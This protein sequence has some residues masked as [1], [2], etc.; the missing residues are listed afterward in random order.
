MFDRIRQRLALR[1]RRAERLDPVP[2]PVARIAP[3]DSQ[4]LLVLDQLRQAS[5]RE[6]RVAVRDLHRLSGLPQSVALRAL[7][8]LEEDGLVEREENLFDALAGEVRLK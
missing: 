3:S 7:R 8:A 1:H 6:D 4:K 2:E 5:A